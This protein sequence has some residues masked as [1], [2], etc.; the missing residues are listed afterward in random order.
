M[1]CQSCHGNMLAVGSS[2]RAGW[3]NQPTCQSCHHDGKRELSAVNVA[4]IPNVW[5]DQRFASNANTPGTGLNLY[6]FSAG[7]GGLQCESC[8]GATHAEYPSS[9]VNDNVLSNDVQ[10]HAGTIGECTACH[11]TVPTTVNGGPHGM[12]T[13]GNAWISSH[14]DAAKGSALASC[15]YCH[16]ADY[17]GTALSQI[18]MSKTFAIEGRSKTFSAGQ[19]VGCYDCHNGP[20]GG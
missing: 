14:H 8:H 17:R 13:T 12:H 1:N 15:A 18:K 2:A 20:K 10:G 16:G 4:G 7:H 5:A 11:K 6:R 9:H 19:N 3:L